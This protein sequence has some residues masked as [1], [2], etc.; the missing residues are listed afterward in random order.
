MVKYCMKEELSS[1]F[2]F[3]V[4]R[5]STIFCDIEA[6]FWDWKWQKNQLET[7]KTEFYKFYCIYLGHLNSCVPPQLQIHCM[8]LPSEVCQ[9]QVSI[10]KL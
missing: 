5:K 6:Q 1:P 7:K 8:V 4:L 9:I 10:A 3:K 2:M